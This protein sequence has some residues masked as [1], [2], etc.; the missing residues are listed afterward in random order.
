MNTKTPISFN[1]KEIHIK[2]NSLVLP[3]TLNTVQPA[4]GIVLFAHGSGSSRLSPRNQTVANYLNSHGI[5][6]LLFDL[7][8]ESES[9]VRDN[10]FNIPLLADRLLLATDWVKHREDLKTLPMGY[11]GASTGAGAALWAAS[12]N[13]YNITAVVARGGRPDLAMHRLKQ[14]V[15]P[16]L[17]LVGEY[18]YPVI[19]MNEEA[20]KQLPIGRIIIVPQATHLFEEK[21]ALEQVAGHAKD[22]FLEH[23]KR[24]NR[25]A[26]HYRAA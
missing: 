12:K 14:V 9:T 24:K 17:L 2:D 13:G 20:L 7:L 21:G 8:S 25:R 19:E 18:D 11:F 22:W 6:T 3:G 26:T 16:T 5:S 4:E 10:V 15:A 1:S 23:F